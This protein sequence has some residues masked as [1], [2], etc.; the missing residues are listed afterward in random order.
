VKTVVRSILHRRRERISN[1][2]KVQRSAVAVR[3]LRI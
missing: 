2:S 1:F 3:A